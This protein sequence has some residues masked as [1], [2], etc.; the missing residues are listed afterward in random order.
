M[1]SNMKELNTLQVNIRNETDDLQRTNG[2]LKE[3]IAHASKN[4]E[5]AYALKSKLSSQ[6]VSSPEKFRKQIIEVG[7]N[8]QNEQKDIK[9][10]E[11]KIRDLTAW[12]QNLDECQSNVSSGLESMH[13]VRSEVERQKT[14]IIELDSTRATIATNRAALSELDQNVHQLNRHAT[15]AEEKLSALKKQATKRGTDTQNSI[16]DLHRQLVDAEAFRLKVRARQERVDG[17]ISRLDQESEAETRA[18]EQ[19][20][21]EMA[22]S[23]HRLEKVVVTHLRHLQHMTGSGDANRGSGSDCRYSQ[24]ESAGASA[25]MMASP[26]KSTYP[27][28]VA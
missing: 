26:M 21:A 10:A 12:I 25:S 23:Y 20:M 1:A 18:N 2:E 28:H 7:Q 6:I 8:L 19:E 4:L 13:E 15:R 14:T 24:N 9:T 27:Q 11:R 16:E 17:E 5:E 3:N 22:A